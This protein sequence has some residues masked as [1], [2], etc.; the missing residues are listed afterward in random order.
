MDLSNIPRR[1]KYFSDAHLKV[2]LSST[3]YLKNL[4]LSYCSLLTNDSVK[5]ISQ[6]KYLESLNLSKCTR[7]T[8][9]TPLQLCTNVC[10][11]DISFCF[12]LKDF[13]GIYQLNNLEFLNAS[14]TKLTD[15]NLLKLF[16]L[17]MLKEIDISGCYNIVEITECNKPVNL[18]IINDSLDPGQVEWDDTEAD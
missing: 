17:L 9:V 2:L 16:D 18:V 6:C 13:N 4:N 15:D 10:A 11:L 5:Y 12:K 7:I 8:S 14:G 3:K 1:W